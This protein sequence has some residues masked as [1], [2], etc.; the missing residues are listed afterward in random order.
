VA[1]KQNSPLCFGL[2]AKTDINGH[3][4]FGIDTEYKHTHSLIYNTLFVNQQP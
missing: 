1:A 2:M 3:M 4:I